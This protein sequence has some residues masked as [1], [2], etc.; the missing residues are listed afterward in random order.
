MHFTDGAISP[1]LWSITPNAQIL[2]T[3][4]PIPA[5]QVVWSGGEAKISRTQ[6]Q[7]GM[8]WLGKKWRTHLGK[9]KQRWQAVLRWSTIYMVCDH[10]K[11]QGPS[12][13]V[14]SSLPPSPGGRPG[15]PNLSKFAC[16]SLTWELVKKTTSTLGPSHTHSILVYRTG[17]RHLY[18]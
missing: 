1:A 11:P 5:S 18:F 17:S 13:P 7:L 15:C 2:S 9:C 14:T 6:T 10:D 4:V 12:G 8:T 16:I 3:K